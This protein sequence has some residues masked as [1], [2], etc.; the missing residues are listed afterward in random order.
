MA[1][2]RALIREL[3]EES[4]FQLARHIIAILP[5]IDKDLLDTPDGLPIVCTG[6]VFKSWH[7]IKPGFIRCLES[8]SGKFSGLKELNLV[9]VKGDSTIGAAILAANVHDKDLNLGKNIDLNTLTC[10]LDHLHLKQLKT[11]TTN[12]NKHQ[13]I[14]HHANNHS[15]NNFT[16]NIDELV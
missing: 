3:F 10:K 13:L 4:G 9:M 8:K 1:D 5:K 15:I 14:Q 7:L 16:K 2:S 11:S 6:S 12:F